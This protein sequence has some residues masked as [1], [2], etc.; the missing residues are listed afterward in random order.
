MIPTTRMD[1]PLNPEQTYELVERVK[2]GDEVAL[3]QLLRRVTPRIQRWARGRLPPAA[4]GLLDTV[5]IVQD[6]V[7][8]S[9]QH[10]D[11][12]EYRGPGAFV[13]YL[14]RG[15]VHRLEDE[16]RKYLNRPLRGEMPDDV[17]AEETSPLDQVMGAENTARY[18]AALAQLHE[19]DQAA[20]VGRFEWGYSYA[21]LAVALGKPNANAARSAVVRAVGR[22]VE[23]VG[24]K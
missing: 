1:G 4:R 8:N 10:L 16:R 18:E 2:Q 11:G 5:D 3:A 22:L 24:A 7:V 14:R 23:R 6:V 17:I 21:E 12:F 9:L 15:L 13:A 20:I 19:D